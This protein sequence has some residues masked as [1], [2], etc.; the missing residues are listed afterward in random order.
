MRERDAGGGKRRIWLTVAVQAKAIHKDLLARVLARLALL[1]LPLELELPVLI[2]PPGDLVGTV[3]SINGVVKTPG[4]PG[5]AEVGGKSRIIV[6]VSLP[7]PTLGCRIIIPS[8]T[9]RRKS[10]GCKTSFLELQSAWA[11]TGGNTGMSLGMKAWVKAT[12]RST[13]GS[14]WLIS[15]KRV[16]LQSHPSFGPCDNISLSR[17]ILDCSGSR[18]DLRHRRRR[19]DPCP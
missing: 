12:M 1:G 17:C 5:A 10:L 8:N 4:G 13:E 16:G 6:T 9:Y 14:R 7:V 15:S 18:D 19:R 2:A 11:L 3:G